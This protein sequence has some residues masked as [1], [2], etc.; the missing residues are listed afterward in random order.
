MRIPSVTFLLLAAAA[1]LTPSAIARPAEATAISHPR[2]SSAVV[3]RTI[4]GGGFVPLEFNLRAVPAFTLYG[5]G[6]MIVPGAITMIYPGPA[7]HPLLTRKLSEDQIQGLLQRAQA[8]GLLAKGRIDYGDMGAMGIADAPTTTVQIN[9]AGRNVKREAYALGMAAP[10]GKLKPAQ[11]AAR[12]AL[13]RFVRRLPPQAAGKA[14]VP[15]AIAI[16]AGPY[17]GQAQAGAEPVAWPL[18][19]N[20]GTAG[21]RTPRTAGYRCIVVRGPQAKT[22]LA[23]LR[24]A[25]ERSV[26]TSRKSGSTRYQV[27]ARPL[28]PDQRTC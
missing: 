28:L 7:I 20:L 25:N 14:Y 2:G 11:V 3:I 24:K 21:K 6:T 12:A 17:R 1:A 13:A 10:A 23:T 27:V 8:A 22:L 18:A 4:S 19:S 26:W 15:R 5:D 16:Y 9:A